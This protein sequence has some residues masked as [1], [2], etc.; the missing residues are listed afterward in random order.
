MHIVEAKE[1]GVDLAQTQQALK[2]RL[3]TTHPI[4]S[5]EAAKQLISYY[6][7]RWIIEQLFRTIKKKG[8]NQEATEL[9]TVQAIQRQTTMVLDAAAKVLQLV[10]ARNRHDAQPIEDAFDQQ[11]QKVL[12]KLN[13]HLE[14]R[15]EKQK[16]PFPQNQLSWAAWI[17]ARLGGWKGYQSQKPPGPMTMKK[18]LDKFNTMFQAYELFNSS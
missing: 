14:G 12:V 18:G 3:W 13:Q 10:Y 11:Q 9:E 8:F 5:P 7:L 6:L 15:T 2:W 17:M 16:N 4:D 1:V